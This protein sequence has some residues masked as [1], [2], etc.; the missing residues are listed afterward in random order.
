ML[1]I[2]CSDPPWYQDNPLIAVDASGGAEGSKPAHVDAGWIEQSR[3]DAAWHH[4]N[5]LGGNA[6]AL[7]GA[8]R[9]KGRSCDNAVPAR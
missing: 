7:D 5:P 2:R 6:E 3:I 8:P 4:R 9:H 1:P